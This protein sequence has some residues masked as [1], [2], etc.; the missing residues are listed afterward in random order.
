[1]DGEA[2]KAVVRRLWEEVW[3]RAD[4]AVADE[5]F[6]GAYAAHEKAFVPVVRA[7][8]P[9]SHHA[10]EELTAE[11][12][13][14][15]TRFTWSGTHRG[16]FAGIP[17]TGRRVEMA[18]VWTHRLAGGRIVEGREWGRFDWD[19]LLR[20]LGEATGAAPPTDRSTGG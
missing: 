11:G 8:F 17:P 20:Q 3:N 18:G 13:K 12:D 19:G 7:A 5:I 10:V 4:L 1:V 15:V 6:D 9:D 14:V 2:N 16:E